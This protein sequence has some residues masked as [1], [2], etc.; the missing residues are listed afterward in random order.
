MTDYKVYLG[1]FAVA[2]EFASYAPYFIGIY[3]GKTKP[4]AFTWLVWGLL[5][6][7]AFIA[8]LISGGGAGSLVLA[9]NAIC[10]LS[11]AAIGFWQRH[12][13]YDLFDWLA[14]VGAIIGIILWWL[15]NQPL[16]AVLLVVLSDGLGSIPIFRKAYRAP[17]EEN[18]T[19]FATGLL[20][21]LIALFALQSFTVTTSLYHFAI[22]VLDGSLI[23]LILARRGQLTK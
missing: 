23:V 3:R 4:H 12:V 9:G 17:F 13:R 1:Y 8:V 22:I 15:T 5:N 18:V 19:S 6:V 7:V 11:I 21:Y 10:C 14:L 2:V 20:Y 16:F